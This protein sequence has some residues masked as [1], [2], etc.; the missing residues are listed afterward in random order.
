MKTE[1]IMRV[2][3]PTD[4]LDAIAQMYAAGLGL[5]VLGEFRGHDGFD[6]IILG[7]PG[8]SYHIEFTTHGGHPAGNAPTQDNLIN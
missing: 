6:G 3:R 2:A 1:A 7:H 8:Q 4:H 5:T